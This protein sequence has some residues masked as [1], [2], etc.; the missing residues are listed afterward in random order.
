MSGTDLLALVTALGASMVGGVFFGFST[1]VMK[2]LAQLPAAQG[3]AAMQRINIVVINPWFMGVF[4][5]TLLLSIA[6]VAAAV[7]SAS[8]ALLAAGC[9]Y[10]V[11]TFGVTMA[12]NVPRNNRLARLEAVSPE[13]AAYWPTYVRE[14]T[15]WNHVRTG[16]ALLAA[17]CAVPVREFN[18]RDM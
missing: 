3:V 10:A 15:R 2:A 8:F 16:A 5:G 13:A 18:G 12:F 1:F 4:M 6:C 17:V 9:L 7:M 14:W 11:G